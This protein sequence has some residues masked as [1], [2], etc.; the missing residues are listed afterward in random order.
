MQKSARPNES[1]CDNVADRR[2]MSSSLSRRRYGKVVVPLVVISD[3]L[4]VRAGL[5]SA[6]L[7]K[8]YPIA[9]LCQIFS[10]SNIDKIVSLTFD[11][12]G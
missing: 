6:D 11:E 4:P 2:V 9:F 3:D 12:S 7:S 5:S 10:R 8:T 1:N